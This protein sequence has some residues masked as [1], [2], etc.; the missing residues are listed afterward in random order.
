MKNSQRLYMENFK[1]YE[2]TLF[3]KEKPKSLISVRENRF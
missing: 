3:F 2:D 1:I